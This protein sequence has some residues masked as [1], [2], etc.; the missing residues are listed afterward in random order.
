MT[1]SRKTNLMIV[2]I[3]T[4][5]VIASSAACSTERAKK[6]STDKVDTLDVAIS[7]DPTFTRN[8]NTFSPTSKKTPGLFYLYEPLVRVDQSDS[9]KV[10]PW[11][12]KSFKY[13]NGGKT[14][15][16]KLRNDIN[17]SDGK[18][19]TS[20]DVKYTL[21]LPTKTKGLGAA[22]VPN[23]KKVTTPDKHTAVVHYTKPQPHDLANYGDSPR[24]IVPK[25]DWSK[26]NPV[27]W[28]NKHPVGTGA[29]SLES[30]GTQS[31]K[32][33][34]RDD[35]WHGDFKGLKHIDI[36]ATGSENSGKQMLL[37]NE[38]TWGNMSWK[39]Y[40]SEFTHQ[41]KNHNHYW[42]Y[43]T[44]G[45][46]GVLFNTK[47]APTDDVHIRRAL[48][49]ALDSK[50]LLKLYNNGQKPANATGLDGGVWGD[51]MPSEL[52]NKRHTQDIK[53][54]R[55]EIRSSGY[56]V[57]GGRLTK[58][59]KTYPLNLKTNSDFGNWS[60]YTRGMHSQWK[61]VLGVNVSIKKSPSEQLG[62]YKQDGDFQMLY[63]YWGASDIWSTLRTQL[64][65][66]YL[67]PI[68]HPANGNYG[69]YKNS[70]VDK[71]LKEMADTRD[72]QKLANSAAKIEDAVLDDVPYA[73]IHSG[74]TFMEVNSTNWTGWPN[75]DNAK[76]VPHPGEPVDSTL[77]MENL[78]PNSTKG[79]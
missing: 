46:E 40:T 29:F 59:G 33:K 38:L 62:E 30:F 73:P 13:S 69:R 36:K 51:Y 6:S 43:P 57:K 75:P 54:A 12:A 70:Q 49:A 22:P 14:L 71:H 3:M 65:A 72:Q 63:D 76:Y 27:K 9:N 56:K 79:K 24:L 50:K 4:L 42:T 25:H 53:R 47:K 18:P 34:V 67:K 64:S 2:M 8:F 26:H 78:K 37:K 1:P 48:Y 23:L 20:A 16:F 39:N 68:G 5:A 44:G 52:R 32:L 61:N 45:S 11:L 35:Y 19:L 74:A 7:T 41:D 10:K 58:G 66:D 60:A 31:I 15:T 28:T 77:T 21:E 55:D 17:W